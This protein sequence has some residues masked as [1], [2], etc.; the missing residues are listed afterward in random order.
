MGPATGEVCATTCPGGTSSSHRTG[1]RNSRSRAD[2][3]RERS[4]G[5]HT[6]R[7]DLCPAPLRNAVELSSF[8]VRHCPVRARRAQKGEPRNVG[9]PPRSRVSY[10]RG[11]SS[12]DASGTDLAPRPRVHSATSLMKLDGSAPRTLRNNGKPGS[13]CHLLLTRVA[14]RSASSFPA[15]NE[16]NNISSVLEHL[17]EHVTEVILVDGNSSDDTIAVSQRLCPEIVVVRQSRRGK[18]NALAAGFSAATGDYIVMI[19]ADGSMDPAEIPS[20]HRRAG[21][22]RRLRQGQPVLRRRRQRRHQP[23]PRPRQQGSEP[24]GEHPV[25]HPLL[26]PLLRLQRFPPRLHRGV[27]PAGRARHQHRRGVG[28]RL[29]DRD[30]DQRPGG[31]SRSSRS[32]RSAASSTRASPARA[33]SAPSATGGACCSPSCASA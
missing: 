21:R 3:A 31:A 1:T 16:A 4:C 8:R 5:G 14:R 17:P 18:G 20:L 25:P 9:L 19:D 32:P 13:T 11:R 30:D 6:R 15:R 22:R 12:V 7:S 29:R 28:R 24:D 2:S 23:H 33:T 27:R 26:R 10:L